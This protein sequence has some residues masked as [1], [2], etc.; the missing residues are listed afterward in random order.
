[1][2]KLR[3]TINEYIYS[4]ETIQDLENLDY[5]LYKSKQSI[6]NKLN[7]LYRQERKGE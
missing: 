1:M 6:A 7:A 3:Q 4:L 2:E 5:L